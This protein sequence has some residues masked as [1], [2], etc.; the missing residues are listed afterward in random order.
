[1][2]R[3]LKAFT[4]LADLGI[5]RIKPEVLWLFFALATIGFV[6]Q[7]IKNMAENK[8]H[9]IGLLF[10]QLIIL[11]FYTWILT[12]Y[13]WITTQFYLSMIKLGLLAG[14]LEGVSPEKFGNP[15]SLLKIGMDVSKPLFDA[16]GV[17]GWISGTNIIMII[18]MIIILASFFIMAFQVFVAILEFKL[19]LIWCFLMMAMAPLAQTSF[20]T[21][22]AL[23]YIFASGMKLFALATITSIGA[24]AIKAFLVIGANPTYNDA[25]SVAFGSLIIGLLTWFGPSKISGVVSGGPSLG[26]GSLFATAAAY[27]SLLG[28][29]ASAAATVGSAAASGGAA[30]AAAAKSY[31]VT[32]ALGGAIKS[33][34]QNLSNTEAGRTAIAGAT[35]AAAKAQGAASAAMPGGAVG[36]AINMAGDGLKKAGNRVAQTFDDAAQ[37]R[38]QRGKGAASSGNGG[39]KIAQA[40]GLTPEMK[41]NPVLAA[42]ALE[43]MNS[44]E[45]RYE[46]AKSSNGGIASDKAEGDRATRHRGIAQDIAGALQETNPLLSD[47]IMAEIDRVNG[48]GVA[49]A[50]SGQAFG[51]SMQAM[52][53]EYKNIATRALNLDGGGGYD[54]AQMTS[55]VSPEGQK[56]NAAAVAGLGVGAE[57]QSMAAKGMSTRDIVNNLGAKLKP[58]DAQAARLGQSSNAS[59]MKL[60]AIADYKAV[61]GI[62]NKG[63]AGFSQWAS[64]QQRAARLAR[65]AQ[66]PAP[67]WAKNVRPFKA[68]NVRSMIPQGTER[69]GGINAS[70]STANL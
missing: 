33:G 47:K 14:G 37:E 35:I 70:G 41:S 58:L 21:E 27:G 6:W 28:G 63:D 11:G 1:M 68:P 54:K 57:I 67:E 66:S 7:H 60:Q 30:A 12:K 49:M 19:G 38:A 24:P 61:S 20:A 34:V 44:T 55:T 59:Q 46:A 43:R 9:P 3:V 18:S 22:K 32:E 5:E 62:P 50:K 4:D 16:I 51:T 42:D 13:T 31:G 69:S 8:G 29:G 17:I 45:R 52:G 56:Q 48:A 2:D 10:G 25:L 53:D 26:A 36:R 65:A 15:S 23:G 39:D 64:Q 40:D